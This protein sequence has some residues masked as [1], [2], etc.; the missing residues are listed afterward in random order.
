MRSW[1]Q[2]LAQ[3]DPCDNRGLGFSHQITAPSCLCYGNKWGAALPSKPLLMGGEPILFLLSSP[4]TNLK[5][6]G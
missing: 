2:A 1:H 6:L 5:S 4:G 3:S